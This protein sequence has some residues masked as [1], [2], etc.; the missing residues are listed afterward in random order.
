MDN[1]CRHHWF[2][3]PVLDRLSWAYGRPKDYDYRQSP[4]WKQYTLWEVTT[5]RTACVRMNHFHD[6]TLSA[7]FRT[8]KSTHV[9]IRIRE[10]LYMVRKNEKKKKDK[11]IKMIYLV[12]WQNH[13]R[14]VHGWPEVTV[15]CCPRNRAVF[16]QVLPPCPVAATSYEVFLANHMHHA[17]EAC[18]SMPGPKMHAA[19][20]MPGRPKR[21][22][23]CNNAWGGDTEFIKGG[24]IS[25]G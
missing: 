17:S 1:F 4:W 8:P 13:E 16:G 11:K 3:G 14:P 24:D 15:T 9:G 5:G 25:S 22:Y 21:T 23:S 10:K 19:T 6:P 12:R 18:A 7:I 20:E 2:A